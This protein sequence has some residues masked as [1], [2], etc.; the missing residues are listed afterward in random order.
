MF[1]WFFIIPSYLSLNSFLLVIA[2]RAPSL[3]SCPILVFE[4]E[5]FEQICQARDE[6]LGR[7]TNG[8]KKR[9][10]LRQENERHIWDDV[11]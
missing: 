3:R 1:I 9:G 8:G 4:Q 10:D 5:I 2:P 11:K 6:R 7:E